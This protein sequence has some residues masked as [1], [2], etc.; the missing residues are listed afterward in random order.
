[1]GPSGVTSYRCRCS[2]LPRRATERRALR[3]ELPT[4]RGLRRLLGRLLTRVTAVRPRLRRLLLRR[5]LGLCLRGGRGL[6]GGRLRGRHR[7]ELRRRLGLLLLLL[8]R[9]ARLHGLA[10]TE[11]LQRGRRRGRRGRRA[12][13]RADLLAGDL[14]GLAHGLGDARVRLGVE[15]RGNL[16]V[17]ERRHL[18]LVVLRR[19]VPE[20]AV[21]AGSAELAG[22]ALEGLAVRARDHPHLVRVALGHL[23]QRLQVLVGQHLRRRLAGLDRGEHLLDGLGLA[24][25][26]QVPGG[27][28]T[29][30]AQD[31]GLALG[32]RGQDRSLLRTLCGED[33]ALL[34]AFGRLDGRLPL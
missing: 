21:L 17:L 15:P 31:A 25:S 18:G 32:L 10:A 2:L 33:L 28:F 23:R 9:R 14:L 4:L 5:L 29:L 7:R 30:R 13:Q 16:L 12:V 26:L 1:T 6:R 24:L 20:H 3:R 8:L 11:R 22:E 34:L 19:L 27:T